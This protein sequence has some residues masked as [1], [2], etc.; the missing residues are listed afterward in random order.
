MKVVGIIGRQNSGKTHLIER[1]IAH[2]I[3]QGKS[4]STIKHTHHVRVAVDTPG[5]DSYRHAAA[6]AAEVVVASDHDWTLLRRGDRGATLWQLLAE[7]EPVDWVLVEGYKQVQELPR[8]E[9]CYR[10]A[11]EPLLAAVRGATA[12]PII[13]SGGARTVQDLPA[14]AAAGA[15]A[16]LAAGMFHSGRESIRGA[17]EALA[18]SGWEVRS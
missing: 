9:V 17:H 12:L 5:K 4:V 6:G 10:L 3:R 16:V 7:L 8:I 1:L 14:A 2:F 15:D 18:A 11:D 13:A